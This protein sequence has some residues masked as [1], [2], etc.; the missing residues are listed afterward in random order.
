MP[1]AAAATTGILVGAT[2][3]ASRLVINQTGPTSLALLRY[4]IGSC[5]LLPLALLSAHIQV[6]RHDLLPLSLLGIV[7]F[8]VVVSLLNYALQFIPSPLPA[9]R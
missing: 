6:E 2:I 3:V 7:Q 1:V 9:P 4:L 5:C 8:G